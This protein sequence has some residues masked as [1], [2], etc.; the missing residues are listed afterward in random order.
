[1]QYSVAD[2]EPLRR[3]LCSGRSAIV[4]IDATAASRPVLQR[5]AAEL[6]LAIES[7]QSFY[8]RDGAKN[9]DLAVIRPGQSALECHGAANP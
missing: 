5:T 7:W 4:I 2:P 1:M 8:Q 6:G 3:T 9:T